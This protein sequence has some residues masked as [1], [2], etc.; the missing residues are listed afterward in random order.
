MVAPVDGFI[1]GAAASFTLGGQALSVV[2]GAV[3]AGVAS[4]TVRGV[5]EEAIATV[6]DGRFAAWLPGN[7]FTKTDAPSGKGGPEV[8][9][10]YDLLLEDGTLIKDAK[11]AFP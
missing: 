3:G 10:S 6:A 4:V 1:E 8:G 11:S 7:V 9:V 5:G 2:T